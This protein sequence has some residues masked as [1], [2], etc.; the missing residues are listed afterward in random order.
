[1]NMLGILEDLVS[2]MTKVGERIGKFN[3]ARLAGSEGG[4]ELRKTVTDIAICNARAV[5]GVAD[6][7]MQLSESIFK[8]P[9]ELLSDETFMALM[10]HASAVVEKT[11]AFA[12][13]RQEFERTE[14][15]TEEDQEYNASWKQAVISL[16]KMFK[17]FNG[18]QKHFVQQKNV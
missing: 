8:I 10:D 9:S 2:G 4:E 18:Y 7:I 12:A 11:N 6:I 3:D 5:K 1:M 13:F 15:I 16:M 17:M 14:Q